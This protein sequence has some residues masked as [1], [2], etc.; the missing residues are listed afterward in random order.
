MVD[1]L[2]HNLFASVHSMGGLKRCH[3]PSPHHICRLYGRATLTFCPSLLR[4]TCH[5]SVTACSVPLRRYFAYAAFEGGQQLYQCMDFLFSWVVNG[6][7]GRLVP[8]S[9]LNHQPDDY[10]W[11]ETDLATRSTSREFSRNGNISEAQR[12]RVFYRFQ[13]IRCWIKIPV[14]RVT[15]KTVI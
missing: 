13:S 5:F 9:D 15:Y 4:L 6:L 10:S 14:Y 11:C 7:V 8:E 1:V 3:S 12:G 2:T